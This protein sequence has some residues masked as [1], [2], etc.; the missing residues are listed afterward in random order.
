MLRWVFGADT[1]PFRRGLKDMRRETQK[2]TSGIK[3]QIAGALGLTAVTGMFRALFT[4]MDRVQ[5]LGIR[6]GESAETVQKVGLAAE[7][8][9]AN[10]EQLAKGLTVATRNA[11]E[12]A[13]GNVQYAESFERLGIDAQNFINLPMEEKLAVLAGTFDQGRESGEQLAM[14]MEVLGRAGG[15]LIPLLSQGQEELQKQFKETNTVSQSTVDAIAE[16]NDE[17]TRL[18]QDLTVAGAVVLNIARAI[19]G[20]LGT[21]V[22]TTLGVIMKGLTAIVDGATAAGETVKKALSGDLEGAAEAAQRF[23]QVGKTAFQEFRNEVQAGV[24]TV[25][26]LY[27]EIGKGDDAAKGGSKTFEDRLAAAERQKEIEAERA[28]LAAEVAKME[29][30]A[31]QRQLTLSERMLELEERRAK[32][33]AQVAAGGDDAATLAARK[34]Q[35]EIEKELEEL[36][37]KD[38]AEAEK[39]TQ[40]RDAAAKELE[41]LQER[42]REV[43]RANKLAG[44]DDAQKIDFLSKERDELNA[45]AARLSKGGDEA[46]ATE[47]R[48]AAKELGGQIAA[49]TRSENSRIASERESELERLKSTGP[50]IATSSLAEIGGGGNAVLIGTETRERRKVELLGEI[51]DALR[52]QE[53]GETTALE[54]KG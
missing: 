14:I 2:F 15:E 21:M 49:L 20:T 7:V 43:E 35:L 27:R 26:E 13:T 38:A 32:L 39:V 22:G 16:F 45:Q 5:K 50:A 19:F 46:G 9:G 12:A 31:R 54:P 6:F 23:R 44:L 30:E 3:G 1:S 10:F 25:Q 29:E 41:N 51:L 4:E 8:A 37:K 47:A 34:E 36:K 33:A 53:G 48:I 40:G 17:V 18:K 52:N 24:G 11:H 42:E 28:K